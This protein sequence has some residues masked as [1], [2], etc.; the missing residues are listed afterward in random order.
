MLT[1]ACAV[2]SSEE[3]QDSDTGEKDSEG[4]TLPAQLFHGYR[5]D[6]RISHGRNV[7]GLLLHP[8]REPGRF[9]RVGVWASV[10]GDGVGISYFEQFDNREV[11]IV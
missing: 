7:Y 8:A 10:A 4:G 2:A 6:Y 11:E 1:L 5:T 3:L 9:V